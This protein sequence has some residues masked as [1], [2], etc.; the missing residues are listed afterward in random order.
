[1]WEYV[2]TTYSELGG[3]NNRR[4]TQVKHAGDAT[5]ATNYEYYLDGP[6]QRKGRISKIT[7]EV[8]PVKKAGTA[9]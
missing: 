1:M 8:G 3:S 7:L 2:V 6:E 4:L 9:P 5:I